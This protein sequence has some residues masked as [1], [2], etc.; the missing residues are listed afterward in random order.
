MCLAVMA[1]HA[2]PRYPLIVAANRDEHHERP[3]ATA[4]WWPEGWLGGRD[5]RAQGT[6]FGVNRAGRFAFVT[7]VREPGHDHPTAPSRGE[8]VPAVLGDP[9]AASVAVLAAAANGAAYNGYNLVAGGTTQA[10]WTSNRTPEATLRVLPQGV[11]G[12]SNAALDTPWPKLTATRTRV[13]AWCSAGT[14]AL[15]PLFAALADRTIPPDG[16]LPPTGVTLAW[17]R[18]LS[19]P[20]I[21]SEGYGTRAS[22]VLAVTATGE[23]TFIEQAFDATGQATRRVAFAFTVG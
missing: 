13:A 4:Q 2:H 3:T 11:S 17:E 20:F 19:A 12:V 10:W 23:A 6:W 16:D 8:I 7:N 14:Q 21:V 15:D 1:V 22:T 18:L 5:L 9:R